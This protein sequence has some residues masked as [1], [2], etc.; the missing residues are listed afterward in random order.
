[1][2]TDRYLQ[3]YKHGNEKEKIRE[4]GDILNVNFIARSSRTSVTKKRK[5][6]KKKE[7]FKLLMHE[8]K[9]YSKK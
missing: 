8:K 7:T 5:S 9:I 6:P 3:A 4:F 1:M 2:V